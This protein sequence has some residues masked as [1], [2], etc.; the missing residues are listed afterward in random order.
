MIRA[1][2]MP[3]P[4][5]YDLNRTGI[6]GASSSS[7][8]VKFSEAIVPSDVEIQCKRASEMPAP[9]AYNMPTDFSKDNKG[10][11]AFSNFR[12]KGELEWIQIRSSQTPGPSEYN[13]GKVGGSV[14]RPKLHALATSANTVYTPGGRDE[15]KNAKVEDDFIQGRAQT[16]FSQGGKGGGTA[17]AK[18]RRGSTLQG[19]V[20][21]RADDDLGQSMRATTLGQIVDDDED[22]DEEEE[23][24]EEDMEEKEGGKD[25]KEDDGKEGEGKGGGPRPP[26]AAVSVAKSEV[27]MGE[28][29]TSQD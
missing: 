22:K 24:E 2:Q 17:A 7:P 9:S 19:I 18:A 27:S 4:D 12:D 1:A 25:G 16:D 29:S 8:V 21:M 14:V 20:I 23:E 3:G 5:A 28:L 6:G 13:V 11:V 26:S 10:G 15:I